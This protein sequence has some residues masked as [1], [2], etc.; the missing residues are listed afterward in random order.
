[1]TRNRILSIALGAALLTSG[2]ALA[3]KYVGANGPGAAGPNAT[4]ETNGVLGAVQ[5]R[6][7]AAACAPAK[8][9]WG[10]YQLLG[11]KDVKWCRKCGE[12]SIHENKRKCKA[13]LMGLLF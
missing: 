6:S 4:G 9:S 5:T 8:A 3:Y 13:S 7:V 2:D 1:M 10:F 12:G 11:F